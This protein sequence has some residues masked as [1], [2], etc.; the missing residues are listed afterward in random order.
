MFGATFNEKWAERCKQLFFYDSQEQ[1]GLLAVFGYMLF[2]FYTGVKTDM[3][4]IHMTKR[5]ATNI[6]SIAIMVPFLFGMAV[7]HFYSIKHLNI[8]QTTKLGII[9]G[10]FSVTP[11]PNI[12]LVLSDLK[13]LNSE[14]GKLAQS[15]ALVTEL[16]NLFLITILNF[17]KLVYLDPSKALINLVGG[18]VFVLVVIFIIRPIM[19]WIIKHTPEGSPVSDH[20]VYCVLI[21]VLLSSHATHRTGSYA[22]FGPFVLGL[23]TPEGPPLGTAIINK[24]DTFVNGILMPVFVTTCAMRVDLKNLMNWRDKSDGTIDLFMV[25]TLVIIVV[26]T[27]V[28]IIGCTLPP[29]YSKMPLKDAVSVSVIMNCKGIVEM[30]AYSLLRDIEVSILF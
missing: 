30:A 6:G 19:F 3:S 22:L 26:T 14:L 7:L 23:A 29:L 11:F 17:T 25:Q 15:S 28:K 1:L 4:M 20:Y 16:F 13:I 9:V 27:A 24:I 12:C 18:I 21:M 8:D 2:L 10:L 5:S